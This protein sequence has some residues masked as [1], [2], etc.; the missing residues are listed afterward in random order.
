MPASGSDSIASGPLVLADFSFSRSSLSLGVR[1]SKLATK[2]KK[3]NGL[4]HVRPMTTVLAEDFRLMSNV[5]RSGLR[6]AT[7]FWSNVI[8]QF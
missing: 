1:L 5:L 8:P 3:L 7:N 6:H 4:V 2:D